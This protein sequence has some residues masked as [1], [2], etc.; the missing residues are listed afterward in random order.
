MRL[1]KEPAE[2]AEP[3][4]CLVELPVLLEHPTLHLGVADR[5]ARTGELR[6]HAGQESVS[7]T[8]AVLIDR[9]RF[10]LRRRRYARRRFPLLGAAGTGTRPGALLRRRSRR[11]TAGRDF[12]GTVAGRDRLRT[13]AESDFVLPV[14]SFLQRQDALRCRFGEEPI[15]LAVP[16]LF[17]VERLIELQ[18][19]LLEPVGAHHVL[20]LLHLQNRPGR[21]YPRVVFF[22]RSVRR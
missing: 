19:D 22:R 7:A 15:E 3:Q 13:R 17:L 16:D 18:H 9:R 4:R 5:R 6:R 11:W 20:A 1:A 21:E 8:Q 12:R 14:G 10:F 2:L